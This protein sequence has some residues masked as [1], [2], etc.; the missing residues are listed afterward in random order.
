MANY[1]TSS[2]PA[3]VESQNPA[4]ATNPA[5]AVN[6]SAPATGSVK[7]PPAEKPWAP[8]GPVRDVPRTS[9]EI[10]NRYIVDRAAREFFSQNPK[11]LDT[12]RT[13][14]RLE[15][16]GERWL[17]LEKPPQHAREKAEREQA[18]AFDAYTKKFL[19]KHLSGA[20]LENGVHEIS[21]ESVAKLSAVGMSGAQRDIYPARAMYAEGSGTGTGF[22]VHRTPTSEQ[23][24]Q[25][26]RIAQATSEAQASERTREYVQALE[27]KKAQDWHD[28]FQAGVQ[29]IKQDPNSLYNAPGNQAAQREKLDANLALLRG[30]PID[31][32]MRGVPGVSGASNWQRVGGRDPLLVLPAASSRGVVENQKAFRD[33]GVLP[34]AGS[35]DAEALLQVLAGGALQGTS[36]DERRKHMLEKASAAI[37]K[38]YGSILSTY[39]P[40]GLARMDANYFS[41]IGTA[42]ERN[43]SPHLSAGSG[44]MSREEQKRTVTDAK[45]A[46]FSQ[47]LSLSSDSRTGIVELFKGRGSEG[48]QEM[49][50]GIFQLEQSIGAEANFTSAQRGKLK[51]QLEQLKSSSPELRAAYV[52]EMEKHYVDKVLDY[53]KEGR[54]AKMDSDYF[55]K[56]ATSFEGFSG[57]SD[58]RMRKQSSLEML[59]KLKSAFEDPTTA[60]L[61]HMKPADRSRILGELENRIKVARSIS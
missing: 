29:R 8:T 37:G 59:E 60:K 36:V 27:A 56:V 58:G 23:E 34:P 32:S 42:L 25:Q 13:P 50:K 33:K 43:L 20:E 9:E 11:L 47:F 28:K 5:A 17:A 19:R 48:V 57:L 49:A 44:A 16:P 54:T 53:A 3:P 1:Q 39:T 4:A 10:V 35:I 22:R 30:E 31:P 26:F 52:R 45:F 55:G 21:P 40:S 51:S 46:M 6:P 12:F 41:G 24:R 2:K 18:I 15:I 14:E 38:Q 7:L 61:S